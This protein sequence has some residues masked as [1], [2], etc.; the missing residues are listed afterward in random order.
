MAP[1]IAARYW[2]AMPYNIS[3]TS[4][5]GPILSRR[6][7]PR[8]AVKQARDYRRLGYTNIRITDV[9]TGE[10]YEVAQLAA[11]LEASAATKTG[12]G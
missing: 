2:V 9:G 7:M 6:N 12:A 8:R 4:P 1:A 11:T 5:I 3:A 10:V